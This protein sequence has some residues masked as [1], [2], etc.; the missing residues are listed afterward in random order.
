MSKR[1][2]KERFLSKEVLTL[3]TSNI[4]SHCFSIN[5]IPF[6]PP[7]I[8]NFK[9]ACTNKPDSVA[10]KIALDRQRNN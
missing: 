2:S 8:E 1:W 6:I 10:Q 5:F 4:V 9:F 7:F 3:K